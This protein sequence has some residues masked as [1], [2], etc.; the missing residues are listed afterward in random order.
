MAADLH[1]AATKCPHCG[2]WVKR[3]FFRPARIIA[4]VIGWLFLAVFIVGLAGCGFM[5]LSG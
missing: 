3:S 2:E 4:E 1:D 5:A